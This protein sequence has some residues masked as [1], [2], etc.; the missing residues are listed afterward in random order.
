MQNTLKKERLLFGTVVSDKMQK[1]G[2]VLIERKVK[3]PMYGKYVKK[4]TK[5]KFH[6]ENNEATVGD[7]VSII[8]TRPISKLKSWKL[9][10]V[11]EKAKK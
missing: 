5:I 4:S 11:L 7:K 6:D 8:Q 3:H 10:R 1:T 2:V 9:D